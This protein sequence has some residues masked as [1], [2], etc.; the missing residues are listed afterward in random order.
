MAIMY[1]NFLQYLFFTSSA[2]NETKCVCITNR[3]MRYTRRHLHRISKFHWVQAIYIYL[4]I[5]IYFNDRFQDTRAAFAPN[6]NARDTNVIEREKN[7][8]NWL[9][10]IEIG[11]VPPLALL[12]RP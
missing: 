9:G 10:N 1:D 5:Y 12:L 11:E 7:T 6:S 4:N 2:Y 3:M 8:L